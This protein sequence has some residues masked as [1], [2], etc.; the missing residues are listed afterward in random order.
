M[1]PSETTKPSAESAAKPFVLVDGSSY[2]F[3]AYHALRYAE[4]TNSKGEPTGAVFGVLNMLYKL[5]D[6]YEP[7]RIAVVFDAPG[8]TFRD[9]LYEDYKAN[10]PPMPEDLRPQIEP[11]LEAVEAIGIPVLRVAGVEADDV[12]GTLATRASEAGFRCDLPR[13]V[14]GWHSVDRARRARRTP[15]LHGPHLRARTTPRR[16]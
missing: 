10:R 9:D 13:D 7:E 1:S 15:D 4:F 12:I 2:L 8:K 14:H 5:L 3:R 11:L 16:A 6:D